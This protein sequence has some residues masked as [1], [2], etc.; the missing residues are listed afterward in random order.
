MSLKKIPKINLPQGQ[1]I[2]KQVISGKNK[3]VFSF[4]HLDFSNPYYNCNGMCDK[5]IKNCFEKLKAYSAFTIEELF[6][7]KGNNTIRFHDI[8]KEDVTDWPK[9]LERNEQLEDSFYQISFGMSKGRAHGVIIENIFYVIW[10]DPHHFL[11]HNKRFGIKRPFEE[12]ESCCNPRDE[13]IES[14]ERTI[15]DLEREN[16]ELYECLDCETKP[17]VGL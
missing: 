4:E 17:R 1:T 7:N 8:K 13:I 14:Y 3:I 11:Y 16:K 12:L 5:G 2:P 6:S 15:K 9:Y 10:L